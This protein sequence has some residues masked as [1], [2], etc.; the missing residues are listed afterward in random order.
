MAFKP[1]TPSELEKLATVRSQYAA[2][3]TPEQVAA[4]LRERIAGASVK[5][6]SKK[7][8][9]TRACVYSRINQALARCGE[10]TVR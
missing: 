7:Y 10:G 1:L 9:V 2:R 6:L 3:L 5:D 4:M 8:G